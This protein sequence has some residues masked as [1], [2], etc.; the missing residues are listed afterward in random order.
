[1]SHQEKCFR[2]ALVSALFG[3]EFLVIGGRKQR[4]QLARI[5]QLNFEQPCAVGVFVDL[6]RR[7]GQV[8]I[9]F[10]YGSGRRGVKIGDGF[11]R[12]YGAKGFSGCDVGAD[13]GQFDKDDVAERILRVSRDADRG[14]AAL[15]FNPLVLFRVLVIRGIRHF[16]SWLSF[17]ENVRLL[18]RT[19]VKRRGNGHSFYLLTTNLD[20]HVGSQARKFERYVRQGDILFKK[21]CVGPACHK[22]NFA[23]AVV[24]DFVF[25]AGDATFH[26]FQSGES[27][28]DAG[29][30]GVL[31]SLTA[32]ELWLL[33]LAE[34]LE[35]CFPDIDGVRDFVPVKGKLA[36]E[37]QRVARPEAARH[38]VELLAGFEYLIPD[39]RTS[40]FI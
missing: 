9:Y 40:L 23:A 19:P 29:G 25:I 34:T 1:M 22:T 12:L 18:F 3:N 30:F 20:V 2:L 14:D 13:L 5:L 15:G 24:K 33:H 4:I 39:H 11:H 16:S 10:G 21:W 17:I 7:S 6:F 36:F 32:D 38:D 37:A 8:G 27:A 26:H 31:Q 35:A 28:F